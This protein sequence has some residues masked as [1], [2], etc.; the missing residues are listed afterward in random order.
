VA[1][2]E[3]QQKLLLQNNIKIVDEHAIYNNAFD[4][5]IEA[6][7]SPEGL[8]LAQKAVRPRGTVV[9]KSTYKGD[10]QVS[11]SSIVVDEITLIGSRCGPFAPALTLLESRQVDP[12][13]LIEARYP[14]DD[15]LKAFDHAAQP[16]TLKVIFEIGQHLKLSQGFRSGFLD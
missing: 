10:V 8:F 6:T 15:V 12:T 13:G 1:R 11:L 4:I 3:K 14:L 5:A 9:L 7:G 2:Y 16:G